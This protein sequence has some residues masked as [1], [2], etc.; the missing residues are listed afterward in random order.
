[1]VSLRAG[2]QEWEEALLF[3]PPHVCKCTAEEAV[4]LLLTKQ[5]LD[6]TW[7]QQPQKV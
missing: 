7:S 4:G 5:S 3:L 6:S 1:M 2:T